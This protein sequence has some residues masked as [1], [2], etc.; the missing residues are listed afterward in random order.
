M[1]KL[2]API[3]LLLAVVVILSAPAQALGKSAILSAIPSDLYIHFFGGAAVTGWL[4]KHEVGEG[5]NWA[6]LLVGSLAKEIMFDRLVFGGA[7]DAA[8]VGAALLGAFLYHTF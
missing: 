1:R 7:I 4:D 3:V 2:K 8:D 6:V 5:E